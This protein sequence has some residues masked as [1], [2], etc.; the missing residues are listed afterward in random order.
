VRKRKRRTEWE[1]PSEKSKPKI[2]RRKGTREKTQSGKN[3]AHAGGRDPVVRP[4][5]GKNRQPKGNEASFRNPSRTPGV[6]FRFQKRTK[7]GPW[8]GTAAQHTGR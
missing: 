2:K 7:G 4:L 1:E 6:Q 3:F 8:R 5:K